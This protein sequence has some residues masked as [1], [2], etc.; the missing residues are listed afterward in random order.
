[1]NQD[2]V[3]IA[4]LYNKLGNEHRFVVNLFP[5]SVIMCRH[6]TNYINYILYNITVL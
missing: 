3:Q 4:V 2:P 5:L 6:I 1:M